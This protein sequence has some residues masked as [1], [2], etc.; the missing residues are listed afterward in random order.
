MHRCRTL[1]IKTLPRRSQW[2]EEGVWIRPS[3]SA[4]AIQL[5]L[6]SGAQLYILGNSWIMVR[7]AR[8]G[9]KSPAQLGYGTQSVTIFIE[10]VDGHFQQAKAAGAKIVEELHGIE[11]GE[12]FNS[13]R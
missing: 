6:A 12:Y 3:I 9:A 13:Q 4:T 2:L 8:G 7:N 10:D 5:E 1:F 11:Y